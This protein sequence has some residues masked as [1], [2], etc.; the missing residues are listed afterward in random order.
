MVVKVA[1]VLQPN[2]RISGMMAA[3]LK[4]NFSKIFFVKTIR[5][6][7]YPISSRMWSMMKK[8]DNM[9]RTVIMAFARPR[10]KTP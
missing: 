4:P 1:M 8:T 10:D 5:L 2:P 9:G 7:K 6:G 3:P